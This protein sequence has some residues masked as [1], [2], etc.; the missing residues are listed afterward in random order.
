MHRAPTKRML[1]LLR[2]CHE[3]VTTSGGA[4]P[5]LQEDVKGSLA[6]LYKRGL[7]DT[8]PQQVNGKT[9]LCLVVTDK[10]KKI[11]EELKD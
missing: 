11:I 5:C 7:V 4:H 2:D 9:I 10:G 6:A 1:L 3:K 8:V